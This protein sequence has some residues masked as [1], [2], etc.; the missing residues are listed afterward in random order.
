MSCRPTGDEGSVL[1]MALVFLSLFGLSIA[2]ILTFAET[3]FRTAA[4]VHTTA[5]QQY[6][7]DAAVEG[8]INAIRKD[9]G[10]GKEAAAPSECF[11]L[12]APASQ[13]NARPVTVQCQGRP[14]SGA[15]TAPLGGGSLPV[16]S[17]LAL[18]THASEG[19]VLSA[20]ASP[21]VSGDVLSKVSR[22]VPA[23]SSL[24]VQG[25]LTCRT[26]SG[27]GVVTASTTDCPAAVPPTA[28]DPGY[29]PPIVNA[30]APAVLPACTAGPTVTMLPGTYRS[31]A[32]L[33]ALTGGGCTGKTFH[34]T[35]GV[36]YFE[37]TDI[38]TH[39]WLVNDPT[40]QV[41]GGTLTGAVF[42]DRC[43]LAQAG[44]E[45]VFGADSRM[46]VTAG[47]LELCPPLSAGQRVAVRGVAASTTA[48]TV[49]PTLT[50]AAAAPAGGQLS[51]TNPGAAA[52]VDGVTAGVALTCN[53]CTASLLLDGFI[54]SVPDNAVINSASLQL[55]H[56]RTAPRGSVDVRVVAGDGAVLD[57]DV[58]PC[59]T[60][61]TSVITVD[62]LPLLNTP[63]RVNGL[64]VLY[65]AVDGP[66]A[67][68]LS[69]NIDGM[70]IALSYMIPRITAT[71]GCAVAIPYAPL[72]ATSCAVLRATGGPTA[73]LAVKGTV[74]APLAAVDLSVTGQLNA[75]TQ[76]GIV[77]R[78]VQLGL[79][80][81]AGYGGPTI[82]MPGSADR[83][84]LLTALVGG[85]P[86]LRADV[87]IA[88]GSGFTPG[89]TVS[90]TR[91]SVLR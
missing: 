23:G 7:A 37:F 34:L 28:T 77:A 42:P 27:T 25:S 67:G 36:Y 75:V 83:D 69:V 1:V 66:G 21:L 90:V 79:T 48:T 17:V 3:G 9:V 52:A 74:Y 15:T 26:A 19:V 68:A 35:P 49:T 43:D 39:Q 58:T 8:A 78:T 44:V 60:P 56:T 91:W 13:L 65:T 72:S 86:V 12:V 22:T 71:S 70:T 5:E 2:A 73:R 76:R 11:S 85:V 84:V 55:T 46:A 47:L 33:N 29:A 20:G 89:A 50:P 16:N 80:S 54:S 87:K 57:Q 4:S 41:V 18:P 32:A 51:F 82:A 88:D 38:G 31:A 59:V 40:A 63:A 45:L 61:C 30:P 53:K 14:G 62:L 10:V 81:G 64:S 24:T 6:S